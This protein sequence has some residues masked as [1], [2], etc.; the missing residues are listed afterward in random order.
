VTVWLK[1][2]AALL[3]LTGVAGASW[4]QIHR[5]RAA[6]PRVWTETVRERDVHATI[7]ATGAV[8][9]GR[10]TVLS[11]PDDG[12][13]RAVLVEVGRPVR[14][15]QV[16]IE[17]DARLARI[18]VERARAAVGIAAAAVHRGE[19]E[20]DRLR[21]ACELSRLSLRRAEH[22]SA[23]GTVSA[24]S[25]ARSRHEARQADLAHVAAL[26]EVESARARLSAAEA[27]RHDADSRFSRRLV[28]APGDGVVT[29]VFTEPGQPV[30][31]GREHVPPS[32]LLTLAPAAV[33]DV[34]VLVD[35]SKAAHVRRGAHVSVDVPALEEHGLEAHV[36]GVDDGGQD[37]V[38]GE[39]LA[40]RVR[41]E[42]PPPRLRAGMSAIVRLT[43]ASR[44]RALAIPN[45]AVLRNRPG[46]PGAWTVRDGVIALLPIVLGL[47]G[48]AYSE[49]LAG[50]TPGTRVVTGPATVIRTLGIG[51]RAVAVAA[52]VRAP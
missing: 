37:A 50:L 33:T 23:A 6:R 31:A 40:V 7:S 43:S 25:L 13:V 2:M 1:S 8:Q 19:A 32:R 46:V 28:Y 10:E 16:L 35:T 44:P 4:L 17:L 26:A 52:P 14:A 5:V 11:S 15:G 30:H 38:A 34:E 20:V 29:A 47:R 24:E 27:D 12:R 22:S 48:D 45:H 18:S 3:A 36:V 39:M 49:V 41:L 9:W 42:T 21:A 51:D